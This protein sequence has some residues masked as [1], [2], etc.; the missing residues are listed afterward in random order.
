MISL[1]GA[2]LY[3]RSIKEDG[4][5]N[6]II[7]V[8]YQWTSKTLEKY[9]TVARHRHTQEPHMQTDDQR[10]MHNIATGKDTVNYF[11]DWYGNQLGLL[12]QKAVQKY[13]QA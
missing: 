13:T 4:N 2:H 6:V 1:A 9:W 3:C 11:R 10:H 7:F 8:N 12:R 5:V